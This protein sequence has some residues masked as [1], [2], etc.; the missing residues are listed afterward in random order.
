MKIFSEETA[1]LRVQE[2][3]DHIAMVCADMEVSHRKMPEEHIS[4]TLLP[5]VWLG[6]TWQHEPGFK[7]LKER[8][9]ARLDDRRHRDLFEQLTTRPF[10]AWCVHYENGSLSMH[11]GYGPDIDAWRRCDEVYTPP[12]LTSPQERS[13]VVGIPIDWMHGAVLIGVGELEAV[14]H[15][16][17]TVAHEFMV[18][19]PEG[20]PGAFE[21]HLLSAILDPHDDYAPAPEPIPRRDDPWLRNLVPR[22]ANRILSHVTMS[23]NAPMGLSTYSA[24]LV[25]REAFEAFNEVIQKARRDQMVY[26]PEVEDALPASLIPALLFADTEKS[27]AHID[28]LKAEPVAILRLDRPVLDRLDADRFTT[29]RETLRRADEHGDAALREDV[30]RAFEQYVREQRWARVRG[31][32]EDGAFNHARIT[33]EN[34]RCTFALMDEAFKELPIHSLGLTRGAFSRLSRGVKEIKPGEDLIIVG[35]LNA[36]DAYFGALPGVGGATVDEIVQ[37]LLE[38]AHHW[39]WELAGLDRSAYRREGAPEQ[40]SKALDDLRQGLDELADLF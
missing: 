10:Q 5:C 38:L 9:L 39:R 33:G 12:T 27:L 8:V 19:D 3:Y 40:M 23:V 30:V 18:E 13:F 4:G 32:S 28:A 35:D 16:L 17:E 24:N 7:R 2:D 11:S 37:R 34:T 29:I 21:P 1:N 14:A 20:F 25:D 6:T 15:G 26:Y 31:V 22:V 36:S